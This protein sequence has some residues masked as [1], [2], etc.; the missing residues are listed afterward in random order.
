VDHSCSR[1]VCPSPQGMGP[2][3]TFWSCCPS[4]CVVLV[5]VTDGSHQVDEFAETGFVEGRTGI[6]IGKHAYE[7]WIV[8]FEGHHGVVDE[9]PDAGLL[10]IFLQ[11]GP[12]RPF[13]N[14]E[15]VV[16]KVFVGVLRNRRF[17]PAR[18]PGQRVWSARV[19]T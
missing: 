12:T 19:W 11:M 3:R 17:R 2:S 13:G 9:P 16:R 6:I 15:D 1:G 7:A 18:E 14:L 10:G 8:A 4:L 5:P